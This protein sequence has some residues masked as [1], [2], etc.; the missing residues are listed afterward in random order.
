M[1][2][3]WTDRFIGPF[4]C[5]LHRSINRRSWGR[6]LS[7]R[8]STRSSHPHPARAGSDQLCRRLPPPLL[9]RHGRFHL[10]SPL[11]PPF[12]PPPPQP[13]LLCNPM[14]MIISSD[15]FWWLPCCACQFLLILTLYWRS[16][17]S[18]KRSKLVP[19]YL[20]WNRR[21]D[22]RHSSLH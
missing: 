15:E 2:V 13:P 5:E 3:D 1:A 9:L 21:T 20:I 6:G 14:L 18:Q 4:Q 22:W 8:S 7:Q 17:T 12:R 10:V 16:T 11:Q 19:F